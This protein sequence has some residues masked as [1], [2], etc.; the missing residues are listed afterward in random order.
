MFRVDFLAI[1]SW[2]MIFPQICACGI[3]ELHYTGNSSLPLNKVAAPLEPGYSEHCIGPWLA[4][5]A[6]NLGVGKQK[7]T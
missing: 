5:A 4:V 3:T 1:R 6:G 2:F 7:S